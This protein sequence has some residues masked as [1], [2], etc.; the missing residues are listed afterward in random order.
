MKDLCPITLLT[1]PRRQMP[2][3]DT[4]GVSGTKR[5]SSGQR[6]SLD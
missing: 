6:R 2:M 1:D 5:A 4:A 3:G